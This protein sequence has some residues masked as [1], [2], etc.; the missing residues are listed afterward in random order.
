MLAET[1]VTP[2]DIQAVLD[3]RIH[4]AESFASMNTY[5]ANCVKALKES[6]FVNFC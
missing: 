6:Y 2:A 5:N 1:G 3:A 4:K